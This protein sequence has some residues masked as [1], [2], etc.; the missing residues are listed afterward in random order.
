MLDGGVAAVYLNGRFKSVLEMC[1][2]RA[3]QID[4]DICK[5]NGLVCF[6]LYHVLQ[7]QRTTERLDSLGQF[8]VPLL[9]LA[10][11]ILLLPEEI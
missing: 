2:S 4:G 7:E 3:D 8:T 5:Y 6:S 10:L 9:G 11:A 1:N